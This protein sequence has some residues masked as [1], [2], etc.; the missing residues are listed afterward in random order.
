MTFI[1]RFAVVV[2]AVAIIVAAAVLWSHASGGGSAGPRVPPPHVVEK[3]ARI[4]TDELGGRRDTGLHLSDTNDLIRTC[5]IE[6]ALA[7]L[8]ITISAI[9]R[10]QRRMRHIP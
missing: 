10:Q 1:R 4:R 8:V 9:R 5:M 7:A 3:F 2:L 6:A